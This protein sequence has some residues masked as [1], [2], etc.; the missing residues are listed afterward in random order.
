MYDTFILINIDF[1]GIIRYTIYMMKNNY[2]YAQT[3]VYKINYHIIWCVKYRR[4][5]L[6]DEVEL[7][8]KET[9]NQIAQDKGFTIE[10][11]EVGEQDHV[12]CFVSAPT[13]L[14][15]CAIVKYL[16][17]IS[18]RHLFIRFPEI[19]EKLWKGH[20]WNDSYF[21]ETIGSTGEKNIRSYI[22]RQKDHQK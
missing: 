21:L 17:G 7:F 9:L 1:V 16:K 3:C 6:T 18:G 2:T 11:C 5:V 13:T 15:P 8:L 14:A 10:A 4:K 12:H 19:K 20:L 22:E